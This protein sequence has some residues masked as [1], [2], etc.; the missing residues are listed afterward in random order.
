MVVLNESSNSGTT[1]TQTSQGGGSSEGASDQIGKINDLLENVENLLNNDFVQNR[2]ADKMEQGKGGRGGRP[3]P[4]PQGQPQQTQNHPDQIPAQKGR[5]QNNGQTQQ[6]EGGQSGSN[7]TPDSEEVVETD[8]DLRDYFSKK[9]VTP[10]GREEL[11]EQIGALTEYLDPDASLEQIQEEVTSEEFVEKINQ[12][13]EQGVLP[14]PEGE[15][16]D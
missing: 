6:V 1:P 11:S 4:Q 15:V 7:P 12:L 2:L 14:D 10:E 9:I 16:S 8:V 13:Q 3:M 5:P